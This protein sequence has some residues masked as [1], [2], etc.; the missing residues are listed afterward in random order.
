MV[1]V[2]GAKCQHCGKEGKQAIHAGVEYV[3]PAIWSSASVKSFSAT[4][5]CDDS[6]DGLRLGCGKVGVLLALEPVDG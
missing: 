1:K 6:A 5:Y 3:Y 2:V 4:A